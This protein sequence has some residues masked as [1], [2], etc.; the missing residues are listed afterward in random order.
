M[1]K[2]CRVVEQQG[3][4]DGDEVWLYIRKYEDGRIKYAVSNAPGSAD[5]QD[6]HHA[7]TL[8]W[9]IEQ[10]FQECKSFLGMADYETR[11]YIGWRRHMLLVMVSHLFVLEVRLRFQKKTNAEIVLP[12]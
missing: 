3:D 1:V 10:S 12:S 6:L 8:R 9:P 7:A 11:S 5:I 4:R 2:N